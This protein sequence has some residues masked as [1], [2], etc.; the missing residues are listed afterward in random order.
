MSRRQGLKNYD[1]EFKS[2][3]VELATQVG[4]TEAARRLDVSIPSLYEWRRKMPGGEQPS[5]PVRSRRIKVSPTKDESEEIVQPAADGQQTK[6]F[7]FEDSYISNNALTENWLAK[8][9][10][11]KHILEAISR[12]KLLGFLRPVE[13]D[14][15]IRNTISV[16]HDSMAVDG[17]DSNLQ[18]LH[19]TLFESRESAKRSKATWINDGKHSTQIPVDKEIPA[20]WELGRVVTARLKE[21]QKRITA[22]AAIANRNGIGNAHGSHW[23][24]NGELNLQIRPGVTAPPGFVPGRHFTTEEK[25]HLAKNLKGSK[26][27]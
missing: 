10:D 14:L 20:G 18:S 8:Y 17:E 12:V 4:Y 24:T 25:K 7:K 15:L 9:P 16:V 11:R 27:K 26:T 22:A 13:R 2:K 1:T 21:H 6:G 19:K 3:A 23:Y 5:K